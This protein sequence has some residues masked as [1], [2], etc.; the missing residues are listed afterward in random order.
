[1]TSPVDRD[2]GGGGQLVRVALVVAVLVVAVVVIASG[3]S[4]GHRVQVITPEAVGVIPGERMVAAGQ[5]VGSITSTRVTPSGEAHLVMTIDDSAWPLPQ[6]TTLTLKMGGTI[7][8]TNR[9]IEINRGR[10]AVTIPDDGYLP[11]S[12]FTVPVEYDTVLNTFDAPTRAGLTRFFDDAGP[13]LQAAEAPL[14]AALGPAA[15]AVEQADAVFRDLGFDTDALSTLVRATNDVVTSV[16]NANPGL[17]Q[18]LSGAGNT[19]AAVESQSQALQATL[20]EGPAWLIDVRHTLAHASRTLSQAAELTTRLA[21]GVTQLRRIAA[22]LD[23]VLREVVHVSPDAIATLSTIRG[24]GPNLDG[25]LS[26]ATSPLLPR[27]ASIGKQAATEVGCVRPYTPEILGTASTWGGYWGDGDL[28]DTFLHGALGITAMTNAE[29]TNTGQFAKGDPALTMD[30]P[31]VPGE[32][33]DQPWFQPQ[34]GITPKSLI[35]ADDPDATGFD[36]N[37]LKEVP[38]SQ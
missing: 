6:D 5:T 23:D 24:A 35:P 15:P 34:C 30:F 22:P 2:Q 33:L 1:M 37:G 14:R 13:A 12:Q 25:L 29:V 3:G 8:Y 20:S 31:Q 7:Q 17:Q 26:R 18:L 27:V 10:S 16:A 38:F 19:F 4:G 32:I 28:K 21:A 36:P 11:S 9:Y